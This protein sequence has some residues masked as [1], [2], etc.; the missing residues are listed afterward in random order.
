MAEADLIYK[1]NCAANRPALCYGVQCLA[2]QLALPRRTESNATIFTIL[3]LAVL[4]H[5]RWRLV[6]ILPFRA[7]S[8]RLFPRHI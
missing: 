8:M 2:A 7:V 4:H 1:F 6:L 3:R 5:A